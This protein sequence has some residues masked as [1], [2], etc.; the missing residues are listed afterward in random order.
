MKWGEWHRPCDAVLGY[1]WP[2]DPLAKGQREDRLLL[3]CGWLWVSSTEES[4]TTGKGGMGA[5]TVLL[6]S[7]LDNKTFKNKDLELMD[8]HLDKN[9]SNGTY[10]DGLEWKEGL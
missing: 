2:S 9:E 3:D 6:S 8:S 1:F 5:T 4:E 7:W 10:T